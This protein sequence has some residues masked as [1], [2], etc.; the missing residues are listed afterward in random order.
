MARVLMLF[1]QIVILRAAPSSQNVCV[2]RALVHKQAHVVLVAMCVMM[3]RKTNA[4]TLLVAFSKDLVQPVK[5][6]H[7]SV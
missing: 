2:G 1:F 5:R 7:G 4:K 6:I 3:L